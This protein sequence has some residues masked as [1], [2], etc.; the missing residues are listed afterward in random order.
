MTQYPVTASESVEAVSPRRAG[1]GEVGRWE[2]AALLSRLHRPVVPPRPR[3]RWRCWWRLV[4]WPDR[5]PI[6][7][8]SC[9]QAWPCSTALDADGVL[10]ELAST[11]DDDTP[12][13]AR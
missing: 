2:L 12:L 8:R 10:V 7:C 13:H 5:L 3:S 4:R 6:L 9:G 1:S 11:I